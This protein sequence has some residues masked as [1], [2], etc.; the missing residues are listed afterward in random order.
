MAKFMIAHINN[1]RYKNF[2]LLKPETISLMREK[3]SPGKNLFHLSSYCPFTGYGLGIIQYSRNWFGHGGSTIGFQNLWSF[4][5]T[6]QKGYI[7][8]T[9]VNGLLYGR[10]NYDSVW[11]TVS[12]IEK[13]TKSEID[14][15][16]HW[17][18]FLLIIA[19]VFINTVTITIKRR[20]A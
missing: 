3:H 14:P 2:Q 15:P 8:L 5:T 12:S 4:N 10:K 20:K 7:I 16:H 9:N 11:K 18:Y 6:S 17:I 1:G 19:I 13:V